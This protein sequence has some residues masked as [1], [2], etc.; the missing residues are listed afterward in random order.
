[1]RRLFAIMLA[2]GL[3][4][5]G[6]GCEHTH[7]VCDCDVGPHGYGPPPTAIPVVPGAKPEPIKEMPKPGPRSTGPDA[8]EHAE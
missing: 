4:G 8:R 3:L 5:V 2:T 7:G 1:M 6:F